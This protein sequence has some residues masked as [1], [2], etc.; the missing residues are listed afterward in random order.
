MTASRLDVPFPLAALV[1]CRALAM[2]DATSLGAATAIAGAWWASGCAALPDDPS[3]LAALAR[4]SARQ[5]RRVQPVVRAALDE[6]L[7]GLAAEH[8]KARRAAVKRSAAASHAAQ[9][10]HGRKLRSAMRPVV[11]TPVSSHPAVSPGVSWGQ[12][13][14]A[15]SRVQRQAVSAVGGKMGKR[16]RGKVGSVTQRT[17]GRDNEQT[18]IVTRSTLCL[19]QELPISAQNTI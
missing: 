9:V 12:M 1:T 3:G 2:A 15:A 11:E 19:R 14:E 4:C 16:V 18:L 10:R 17:G 5:W 7:P 8:A 6:V 13:A